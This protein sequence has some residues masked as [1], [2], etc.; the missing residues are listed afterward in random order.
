MSKIT[1]KQAIYVINSVILTRTAYRLQVSFLTNKQINYITNYYTSI[2]KSKARLAKNVPNSFIQHPGI[3]ALKKLEQI[4]QQ[5]H[6][7]TL[8]RALTIANL[9]KI[10]IKSKI[11]QLQY[12]ATTNKSIL[13][14]RPI[15]P[16]PESTT[17]LAYMIGAIHDL[18]IS[19]VQTGTQWLKMEKPA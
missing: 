17:L 19:I 8:T 4:Q 11:K 14:E 15:S 1:E 9:E 10:P 16:T 6:I 7:R 13:I 18:G 12:V 2:V 5:Q 3:L